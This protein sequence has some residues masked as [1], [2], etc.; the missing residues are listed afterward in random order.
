MAMAGP[1]VRLPKAL[2]PTKDIQRCVVSHLVD[3]DEI[4]V[5]CHLD[6][7]TPLRI[8]QER[9]QSDCELLCSDILLPEPLESIIGTCWAAKFSSDQKWYRVEVIKII[10]DKSVID[11]LE[12]L[13]VVEITVKFV[14]YGNCEDTTIGNLKKLPND[15]VDVPP[16][17][18]KCHLAYIKPFGKRWV[19]KALD[20]LDELTNFTDDE[21][22]DKWPVLMHVIGKSNDSFKVF[23]WNKDA[24]RI[25]ANVVLL[26]ARFV[27]DGLAVSDL[28]CWVE[29]YQKQRRK[30]A[31]LQIASSHIASVAYRESVSK[32]RVNSSKTNHNNA[33]HECEELSSLAKWDP[34]EDHSSDSK[35]S[36]YFNEG[37]INT[38]LYGYPLKDIREI[39]HYYFK[40][41]KCR[42]GKDCHKKHIKMDDGK[43]LVGK[44]F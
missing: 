38:R 19:S 2:V 39:C 41:G 9:L 33:S 32:K 16:H 4:Y 34:M 11:Q 26:N 7:V 23:M 13:S 18:L 1:I 44:N 10:D 15:L 42:H 30:R 28:E 27:I 3:P 12:D 29:E 8:V 5:Q 17:S 24:F 20:L 40:N 37:D 21:N 31:N 43:M 6:G 36:Y 35:N 22:D 14:D 25:D